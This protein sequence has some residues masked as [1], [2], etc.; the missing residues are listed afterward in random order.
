MYKQAKPDWHYLTQL[1]LLGMFYCTRFTSLD[2]PAAVQKQYN[3][4]QG[5]SGLISV[6]E[7]SS[8]GVQREEPLVSDSEH[9]LR[10]RL[11]LSSAAQKDER[12]DRTTSI[13]PTKK[14]QLQSAL[15]GDQVT[16][17]RTRPEATKTWTSTNGTRVQ[18]EKMEVVLEH[19]PN[20]HE[21]DTMALAIGCPTQLQLDLG[22]QSSQQ[23]IE[24]AG[25]LLG[26]QSHDEHMSGS[27]SADIVSALISGGPPSHA[28]NHSL[29]SSHAFPLQSREHFLL[30]K[31]H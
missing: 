3:K 27:N 6:Q 10:H 13:L 25:Q 11:S 24:T 31:V 26:V 28:T 15:L 22:D 20:C 2:S 12:K 21:Q 19:S 9:E 23:P 1:P 16:K 18:S 30:E 5:I 4:Q 7:S 17:A 8:S 14:D 29:C